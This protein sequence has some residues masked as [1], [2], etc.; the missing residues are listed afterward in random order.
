MISSGALLGF[1]AIAGIFLG[2]RI[3]ER[4]SES[5]VHVGDGEH[6]DLEPAG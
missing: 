1:V 6:R 2:L 5:V 3:H 4:Q